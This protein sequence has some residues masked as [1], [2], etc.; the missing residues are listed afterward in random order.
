MKAGG[1]GR[2]AAP[3]AIDWS[4]ATGTYTV[5]ADCTGKAQLIFTDGR[6]PVS[7]RIV[8]VRSGKEVRTVVTGG[9]SA[10]S[11]IGLKIE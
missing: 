6:P 10:S 5:N 7:L 9:G 8:V 4:P 11:S 3:P 2:A 1:T